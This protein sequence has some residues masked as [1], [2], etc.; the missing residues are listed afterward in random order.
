MLRY[1]LIFGPI[2]IAALIGVVVADSVMDGVDLTD[3][4]FQSLFLGRSYL[5][6][7]LLMLLLFAVLSMLGSKEL[8]VIFRAKGVVIDTPMII[9]SGLLGLVLFYAIPHGLGSQTAVEIGR[10]HV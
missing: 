4:P 3:T 7:G 1:R 8:C 5:P 10:A 6:A 2:M 9:L